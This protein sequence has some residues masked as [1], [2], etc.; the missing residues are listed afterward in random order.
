M[1]YRMSYKKA[2]EILKALPV[3]EQVLAA[4]IYK[5]YEDGKAQCGC[6][7]GKILPTFYAELE[8]YDNLNVEDIGSLLDIINNEESYV[9]DN[10]LADLLIK[11]FKDLEITENELS[12]LQKE[13]DSFEAYINGIT[14]EI[15]N[16][17]YYS[18]S[19]AK[20]NLS[21]NDKE[22]RERRFT[23]MIKFMESA[24]NATSTVSIP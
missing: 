10:V 18:V 22:T 6:A 3:E 16:G 24:D 1:G 8:Q 7:V 15:Y 4:G 17:P 19:N 13:N 11:D 23:H 20:R 14:N 2:L 5:F 12:N 9:D 21:V